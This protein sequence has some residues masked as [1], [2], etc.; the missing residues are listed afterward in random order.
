MSE[1]DY[2]NWSFVEKDFDQKHW[3]IRLEGG[4]YHGVV[5]KYESINL[6]DETESIDFDYEIIDW[7]DE[8]PH[9]ETRFNRMAGDILQLVLKD[10]FEAEDYII[11]DY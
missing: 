10:A 3:Y 5:Y 11:G 9:G 4:F 7:L 2:N 8:D 1:K 6:N